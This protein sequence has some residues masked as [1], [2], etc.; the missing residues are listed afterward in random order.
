MQ[1][2]RQSMHSPV[3]DVDRLDKESALFLVMMQAAQEMIGKPT[4]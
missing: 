3:D 1:E 4:S 2:L